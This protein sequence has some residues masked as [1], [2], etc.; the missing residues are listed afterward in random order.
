LLDCGATANVLPLD[1][2]AAIN[3]RLT[4]LRPARSKLRMFDNTE[5]K[6][7]GMLTANVQHPQ[8]GKRRRM[9]FYVAKTHNRAILGVEACR[10]MDLI[11]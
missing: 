3:P 7:I 10:E 8:S 5:L 1:C 2:A 6:T 9:E 4:N 11:L